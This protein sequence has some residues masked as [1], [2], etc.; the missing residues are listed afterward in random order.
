VRQELVGDVPQEPELERHVTDD[1]ELR[2]SLGRAIAVLRRQAEAGAIDRWWEVDLLVRFEIAMPL[3]LFMRMSG[4]FDRDATD[5][6]DG[7]GSHESP[8]RGRALYA[9]EHTYD[10]VRFMKGTETTDRHVRL[11]RWLLQLVQP[12]GRIAAQE[13]YERI[14]AIR[15]PDVAAQRE[16]EL[17]A[18]W[19]RAVPWL[20]APGAV[21]GPH[22]D[23][24]DAVFLFS[25]LGALEALPR[26]V[27]AVIGWIRGRQ[28]PDGAFRSP[29]TLD[30]FG[31]PYGDALADTAH[32]LRVLGMF[33]AVPRDRDACIRWLNAECAKVRL[34]DLA[35]WWHVVEASWQLGALDHF[36]THYSRL[37][38][39]LRFADEADE[40]VG[41]ELYAAVRILELLAA[42]R[43]RS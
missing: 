21:T 25:S 9:V 24:E 42:W 22:S 37:L 23:L 14:T 6:V 4:I 11:A 31:A 30:R 41:F 27:T 2:S 20:L 32:A 10:V 36:D 17:H 35:R 8:I 39:H 12:D 40:R 3:S 15:D 16:R 34:D 26:D 1:T 18:V 38:P 19:Q 5:Y 29:L 43:A 33:S 13:E 28:S 7:D